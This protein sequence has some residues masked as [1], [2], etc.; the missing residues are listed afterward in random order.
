MNSTN[1]VGTGW[2]RRDGKAHPAP[3]PAVSLMSLR[4]FVAQ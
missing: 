4:A 2:S 3:S 1:F